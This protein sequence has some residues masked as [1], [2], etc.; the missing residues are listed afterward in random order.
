MDFILKNIQWIFSGIGVFILGF[1]FTKRIMRKTKINQK[2]KHDSIGIQAGRD[3]NIRAK[4][5]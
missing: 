5:D 3:V 1:I 2:I 4:N